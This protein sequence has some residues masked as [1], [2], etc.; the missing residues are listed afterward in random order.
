MQLQPGVYAS[1]P[2]HGCL[3]QLLWFAVIGWWAGLIWTGVAWFLMNT[4]ILIPVGVKMLN[5]VPQ[6]IALRGE[7]IVDA[8]GNAIE[9]PQFNLLIRAA[10]F[11][12]VG[13]WLSGIWLCIA[14][15][16]CATIIFMPV[17]FW[18]FDLTPM[19][20]SLRQ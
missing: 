18:M 3:A 7:R 12:F 11:F 20:V 16:A 14:Y 4:Y 19:V 13:W 15:L 1:A 5:Y 8:R 10:W 2:R 17:G 6:I 9:R